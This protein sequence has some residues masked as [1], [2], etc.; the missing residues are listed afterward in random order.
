MSGKYSLKNQ[1][2][3][4]QSGVLTPVRACFFSNPRNSLIL[5]FWIPKFCVSTDKKFLTWPTDLYVKHKMQ[6]DNSAGFKDDVLWGDSSI[7]FYS[8]I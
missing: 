2:W 5:I 7:P 3:L 4:H 6:R 1:F 8:D